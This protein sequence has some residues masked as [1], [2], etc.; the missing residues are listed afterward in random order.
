MFYKTD[1]LLF[2]SINRLDL[3]FTGCDSFDLEMICG[4]ELSGLELVVVS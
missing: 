4:L 2:I 1:Y 3:L